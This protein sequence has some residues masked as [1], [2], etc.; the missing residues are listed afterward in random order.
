MSD[1]SGHDRSAQSIRAALNRKDLASARQRTELARLLGLADRDV[2]AVQHLALAGPL[3][4]SQLGAQ[5]CM[6][7][8]GATA[9]VQR[10][11]RQGCIAREPHPHDRR[12]TLLRLTADVERRAGDA[13][14]PLVHR[15]DRVTADLSSAERH[16][17]A[18][19]LALIADAAELHAD[20]LMRQA[21][22]A[23]RAAAETPVPALWA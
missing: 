14:A 10:L 8:G 6:T 17:L 15:I 5:L 1:V 4:A 16:R 9:L 2:L 18:E 13:V 21:D 22:A 23:T 7:S 11:E 3:T 12:S 20:E 19:V